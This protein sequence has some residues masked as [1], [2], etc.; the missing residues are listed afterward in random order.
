MIDEHGSL[1]VHRYAWSHANMRRVTRRM[2]ADGKLI[3]VCENADGF[4]YVRSK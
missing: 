4:R 2:C 1:F 3:K